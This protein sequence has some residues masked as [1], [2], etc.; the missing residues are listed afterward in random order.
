MGTIKNKDYY[1]TETC[2]TL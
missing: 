2:E 1:L